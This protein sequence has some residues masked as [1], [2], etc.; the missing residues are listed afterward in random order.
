[1]R[2]I[3]ENHSDDSNTPVFLESPRAYFTDLFFYFLDLIAFPEVYDL[4]GGLVKMNTRGLNE[5]ELAAA[6]KIYGDSLDYSLI[7]LDTNLFIGDRRLAAAYVGVCTINFYSE[8]K[9]ELLIHELIH[10]WQYQ[11]FGSVY[12]PRSLRA[13][14]TVEAYNYQGEAALAANAEKG[15]LAFNYEQQG[16]VIAD[17][18]RIKHH[19]TPRWSRTRELTLYEPY[20][21]DLLKA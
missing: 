9:T 4:L 7:R 18:F 1:M 11:H 13:Q 17:Y 6:K 19:L 8:A 21:K 12:I 2:N 20:V 14:G 16:E 10:I 15:L 5:A 3:F